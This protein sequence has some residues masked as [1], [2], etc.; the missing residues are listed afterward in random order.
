MV[1][2]GECRGVIFFCPCVMFQSLMSSPFMQRKHV[3]QILKFIVTGGTGAFLEFASLAL[4]VEVIDVDE[5]VAGIYS[6]GPSLVYVFLMHKYFTF[7]NHE[8]NVGGQ[9]A[10]FALVYALAILFNILLYSV[11]IWL[12]VYYP[13]AKALAIAIVAVWNY[14]L[15]HGFIFK[16]NE[17]EADIQLL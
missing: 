17:E 8:K 14:I 4:L 3:R 11:F 16:K 1:W 5:S 2:H 13:F 9:M 10:K 15:A 12:G 7:K 6:L